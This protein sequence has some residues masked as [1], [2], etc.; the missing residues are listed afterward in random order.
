MYDF[1]SGSKS[2]G[3]SQKEDME[4][5]KIRFPAFSEDNL[6]SV[7]SYVDGKTHDRELTRRVADDFQRLGGTVI[8]HSEVEDIVWTESGFHVYSTAG[9]FQAPVMVN[10]TGPWIDETNKKYDFPSN[11][12]VRKVSG[13]HLIFDG[14]VVPDLMFMQTSEKRIFFII[15]EPENDQ[16]LI[17]TT[18]RDEN[19]YIDEIQAGETDIQYLLD[20]VNAYLK[21]EFQLRRKDVRDIYIGVRPLVR[22]KGELSDVSREYKLDLHTKGD[23]KLLHIFGGKLTTYLS[24]AEKVA[25]VLGN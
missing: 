13:I 10:A 15:P 19:G 8:V 21:P 3:K 11:F 24:L 22:K 2:A 14:L 18:E 1:L 20:Q 7:L 4:V 12:H 5:F 17:G 23:T 16:T 25:K 9:E 6:R